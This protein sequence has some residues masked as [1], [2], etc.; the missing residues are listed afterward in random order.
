VKIRVLLSVLIVPLLSAC[1]AAPPEIPLHEIP[2]G[3]LTQAL[4]Q[5]RRA[6]TGMKAVAR[7]ETEHKGRK[8]SYESVAILQQRFEKLR[9]E[10]HGPMGE[11]IFALVWDGLDVM[12]RKAGEPEP[13]KVGLFG[14]ERIIGVSLSPADLCAVLSGNIPRIPGNAE[15][16]V[17]CSD[18]GWCIMEARRDDMHLRVKVH[19]PAVSGGAIKI[20]RIESFQRDH[21]VFDSVFA[22][23]GD[24]TNSRFPA[25][26]TLANPDRK[27]ILT[28]HYED[29]EADAVVEDSAFILGGEAAV[30]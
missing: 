17:H 28:V 9:V 4:E 7:V 14:L 21:L 27:A 1:V 5:R 26:I 15:T 11:S 3:P 23:P 24:N 2:A 6:F 13:V 16:S 25:T 12:V 29:V 22:Y 30:Q 19:M 10:G 18:F 20:D 8:R